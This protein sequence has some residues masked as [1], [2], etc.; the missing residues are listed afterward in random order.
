MRFTVNVQPPEGAPPQAAAQMKRMMDLMYGPEGMVMRTAVVGGRAVIV[1]GDAETMGRAIRAVRGEG[2]TLTGDAAVA[3]A[4]ARIPAGAVGQAVLSVPGYLNMMLRMTDRMIVESLSEA[5]RG[6]AVLEAPPMPAAPG[7][8]KPTAI[9]LYLDGRT[10]RLRADVPA[11][12]VR[13]ARDLGRAFDVRTQWMMQEH[14]K[15]LQ[16]QQRRAEESPP[17]E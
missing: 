5:V 17:V 3:D 9:G 1:L 16:E 10:L 13:T 7:L 4:V 2:G 12:E 11:S 14:M 6:R 8:G 15:W